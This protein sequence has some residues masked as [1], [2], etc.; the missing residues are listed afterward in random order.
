MCG[1][2]A[3]PP[4]WTES[5]DHCLNMSHEGLF[6][7]V[8]KLSYMCDKVWIESVVRQK[9][10]VLHPIREHVI[11]TPRKFSFVCL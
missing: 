2:S 5:T 8:E 9:D 11:K 10:K 1:L 4:C 6:S 7:A 3:G